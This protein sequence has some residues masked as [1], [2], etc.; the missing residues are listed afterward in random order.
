M[1]T[2]QIAD[3]II[4][5][6]MLLCSL[7]TLIVFSSCSKDNLPTSVT[8]QPTLTVKDTI[9]LLNSTFEKNNLD[10]LE[11]WQI[12]NALFKKNI[13]FSNDVPSNGGNYSLAIQP[14]PVIWTSLTYTTIPPASILKKRFI[15]SYNL[16]IYNP[17]TLVTYMLIWFYTP[18]GIQ[19]GNGTGIA[20]L[21]QWGN[22]TD[23]SD[24]ISS[25]IDSLVLQLYVP[26]DNVNSRRLFDNIRLFEV[27]YN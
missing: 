16:K 11:G 7:I 12:T 2:N 4:I 8:P 21:D 25:K 27:E 24:I 23:I 6:A 1:R 14:A 9:E 19:G 3:Y 10:S 26:P 17:D 20:K 15:F 5:C 18:N 13:S 22:L